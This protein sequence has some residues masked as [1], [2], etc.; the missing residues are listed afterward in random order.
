VYGALES[1]AMLWH[2]RSH[3]DIIIIIIIINGTRTAFR[4]AFT[5]I[6]RSVTD[7]LYEMDY[8]LITGYNK[9]TIRFQ[10]SFKTLINTTERKMPTCSESWLCSPATDDA[11][12]VSLPH[13]AAMCSTQP[14]SS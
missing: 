9:L 10:T 7:A 3:H 5:R 11:N 4:P 8:Q 6:R 13:I 2:L 12:P 1:V 14:T